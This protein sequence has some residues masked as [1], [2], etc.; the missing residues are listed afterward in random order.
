MAYTVPKLTDYSSSTL[1]TAEME[2]KSAFDQEWAS[3]EHGTSVEQLRIRWLGR[4]NGIVNKQFTDLWLKTAPKQS[5]REVGQI[6]NNL[7]GTLRSTSY[8]DRF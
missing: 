1:N 3:I 7:R 5:K 6:V 2:A 8:L 4:E